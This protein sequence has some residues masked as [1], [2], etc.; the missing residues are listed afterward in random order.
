VWV[1]ARKRDFRSNKETDDE[2]EKGRGALT[3]FPIEE[4][5]VDQRSVLVT[6]ATLDVSFWDDATFVQRNACCSA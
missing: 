6:P 5:M 4:D 1:G 2:K 3:E